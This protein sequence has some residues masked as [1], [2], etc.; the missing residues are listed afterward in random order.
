MDDYS[1]WTNLTNCSTV[2]R[3][4]EDSEAFERN[5]LVFPSSNENV[6]EAATVV[7]IVRDVSDTSDMNQVW[8]NLG[9]SR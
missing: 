4:L 7:R 3:R 1:L 5:V 8:Y 2:L 9:C 6:C